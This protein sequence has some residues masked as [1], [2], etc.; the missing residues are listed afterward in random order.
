MSRFRWLSITLT[1]LLLLFTTTSAYAQTYLFQVQSL[2][3]NVY[4]NTDGT[5]SIDYQIVFKNS[6]DADPIDYVDIGIPNDSYSLSNVSAEIDGSRISD[7]ENSE[8]VKPGVALGLGSRAIAPG[9]SGTLHVRINNIN[10]VFYPSTAEGVK[11]YASLEFS[12]TWF[13]SQYVT[14]ATKMTVTFFLPPGISSDE[15]R[16]HAVRGNW[17]GNTEPESGYDTEGRV[18]YRWTAD[19]A[20]AYTQYTFG[21]SFPAKLIPADS[22][23]KAPLI[24]I[25]F[26]DVCCG[27]VALFF[28]GSFIWGIYEAIWG[29]KKR[30]L[31]YLPPKISVEGHGIKRGL[32]A[33]EAAIL[34]EQPIDR[35]MTMIL[36]SIIKKNAASVIQ[37]EPL[38][39]KP[40]SPLPEGLNDY[41]KEFITAFEDSD[42][43]KRKRDLQTMIIN[44]VKNVGEKM[45]GF[46][47]KETI[48]YYKDIMDRAWAQVEMAE[49]P[50]VKMEKYDQ[51][52]DWAMLDDKFGDKTKEVFRTEPV[53]LPNW[54]GRYD[55]VF[56]S[57][58]SGGSF[59]GADAVPSSN[60]SGGGSISLPSLPGADFAASMV[61]GIQ[62]FSSN[63]VG[64]LTSFTSGIT[65]KTNPVPVTRSTYHGGGGGGSSCACACAC[66]GCACACAGGGR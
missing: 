48:A 25:S 17:P 40:S 30:K 55:P 3:V 18:Y 7:I 9:K 2:D 33:V 38:T 41:E 4:A 16:Y 26:E 54:W 20:N 28:A 58:S 10:R 63:V 45:K 12:P 5:S 11:D 23:V 47:R 44:L 42:K 24:N 66:A 52:M 56:S 37:K 32:T 13:G 36:F 19:Y 1:F 46:S 14:G 62:N 65:D 29:A 50:Q 21:A 49:T 22:I 34:M 6:A 39:I 61:G 15:P 57:H 64:D 31:Q 43:N 51:Y 27:G 60:S 8:Y 59:K 53:F 35:V